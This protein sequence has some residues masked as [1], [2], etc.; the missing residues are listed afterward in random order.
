MSFINGLFGGNDN[1]LFFLLIFLVLFC[2]GM[3]GIGD[4]L[5][6]GCG[7]DKCGSDNTILFFVILVLVL[8]CNN[9]V[10]GIEKPCC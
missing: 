7:K 1:I 8:F 5:G 10:A 9:G 6:C 4:I 2:G 3:N